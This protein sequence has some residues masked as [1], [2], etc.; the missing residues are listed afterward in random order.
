MGDFIVK[1][2]INKMNPKIRKIQTNELDIQGPLPAARAPLIDLG[3]R[4]NRDRTF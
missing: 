4:S 2:D 1:T 3:Q